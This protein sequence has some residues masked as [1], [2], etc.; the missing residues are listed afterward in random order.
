MEFELT[1]EQEALRDATQRFLAAECP[2]A[3]VR[4]LADEGPGYR[5]DLWRTAARLGW[6]SM[7]VPEE[8]GGG[9]VSGDGLRD[10]AIIAEECGRMVAPGPLHP[11]NI[12]ASAIA[13]AGTADQCTDLL[14][15][16]VA[17]QTIVSWAFRE[18]RSRWQ[19]QDVR[20]TATATGG[21][22]VLRGEKAAVEAAAQASHFLVTARTEGGLSQFIVPADLA[23]IT[24]TKLNSIDLVR[25]FGDV[26]FD[27]VEVG[28]A[29][30]VGHLDEAEA[31]VEYQL[32]LA[33]SLQ[34]AEMAGA[35]DQVFSFTVTEA[36]NRHSFG[37]PLA[38]YQALKHRFADMRLRLE[39]CHATAAAAIRATQAR[40]DNATELTSVAKSY[41]GDYGPE[42]VQDCIQMHGG[43]GITWE[44]D[45][46]LYLRRVTLDRALYGDP[47]EHRERIAALIGGSRT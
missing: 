4:A 13:T 23:G 40:A 5:P 2:L 39:A 1:A 20:L 37:R 42:I 24:V 47:A 3:V 46:H 38:S 21:G 7:L 22:F 29:A 12:V 32:Q 6:T 17:G 11:V 36:F 14:P 16:I 10:L 19:A 9:S 35:V 45:L 18:P 8:Y 33:L 26:R 44:H 30:V 15:A 27:D 43:M 41:I 28:A 34:C 25:R 31:D